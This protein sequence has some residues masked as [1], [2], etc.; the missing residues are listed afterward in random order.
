MTNSWGINGNSCFL[1]FE[2]KLPQI[3]HKLPQT[4]NHNETNQTIPRPCRGDAAGGMYKQK[5]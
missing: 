3:I 4:H 1:L 5:R 2:H